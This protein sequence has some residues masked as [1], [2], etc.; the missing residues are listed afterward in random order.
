MEDVNVFSHLLIFQ[1]HAGAAQLALFTTLLTNDVHHVGR[2]KGSQATSVYVNLM[3]SDQM[4][5]VS[6]AIRASTK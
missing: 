6:S 1:E 4:E 3:Q 5:S 2:M